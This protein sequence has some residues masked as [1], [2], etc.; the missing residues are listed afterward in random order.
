M[1]TV[2]YEYILNTRSGPFFCK[3]LS[4]WCY[5]LSSFSSLT[6]GT[7]QGCGAVLMDCCWTDPFELSSCY[8]P[9]VIFLYQNVEFQGH[10]SGMVDDPQC[11]VCDGVQ[12]Q[13]SWGW[14]ERHRQAGESG[15]LNALLTFLSSLPTRVLWRGELGDPLW[16]WSLQFSCCTRPSWGRDGSGHVPPSFHVKVKDRG[17]HQ[18]L[19]RLISSPRHAILQRHC[20][21]LLV[22]QSHEKL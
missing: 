12:W 6:F 5:F 2:V 21:M 22:C 20:G 7:D 1:I 19:L 4:T 8:W 13:R 18:P 9:A 16:H 14:Q 11:Y 3:H 15:A 10:G 17:P